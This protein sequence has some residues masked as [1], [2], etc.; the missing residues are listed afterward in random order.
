M[1]DFKALLKEHGYRATSG[2]IALLTLLWKENK[3]LTVDEIKK[4]LESKLDMVTLY[5][6][7]EALS[8]SGVVHRVELGHGHAHYEL[9]KKHHHHVVCTDCGEI[10]DVEVAEIEGLEARLSKSTRRFKSIYSHNVEFFGLC[11]ACSN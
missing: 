7:L 10:E 8:K 4:R 3:P 5:R 11:K 9:E 1:Q 6:A 2:R